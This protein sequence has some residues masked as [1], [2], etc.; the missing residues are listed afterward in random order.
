V[1]VTIGA[2]WRYM[3]IDYDNGSEGIELRQFELAYNG[4]RVWFACSR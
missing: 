4:P 3:D 1:R 2:G